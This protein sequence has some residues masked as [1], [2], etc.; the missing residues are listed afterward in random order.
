MDDGASCSLG[1]GGGNERTLD[2]RSTTTTTTTTVTMR[3]M[4]KDGMIV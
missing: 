3:K 1:F 4:A 2:E